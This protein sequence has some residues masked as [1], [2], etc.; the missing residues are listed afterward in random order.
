MKKLFPLLLS[1]VLISS[2][3]VNTD[4]IEL[5]ATTSIVEGVAVILPQTSGTS[6]AYDQTL[7]QDLNDLISNFADVS[8]ININSLSYTYKN[9]SGN[10]NATIEAAEIVINGSTIASLSSVNVAQEANNGTVFAITDTTILNQLETAFLNNASI[11]IQF[12]GT[13]ISDEG[14]AEFEI[15][16]FID[17]TVT[18]S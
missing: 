17:V 1:L 8:D 7:T 5:T 2:C 16:L 14:L 13:A 15:E 18:F 6:V 10:T 3:D 9:F 12:A 4:P 11:T